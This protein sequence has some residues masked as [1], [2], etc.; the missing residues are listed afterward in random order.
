MLGLKFGIGR[1]G[2]ATDRIFKGLRCPGASVRL[3]TNM[4]MVM[5][6]LM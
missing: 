1:D 4:V 5:R 2:H 3:F 6:M